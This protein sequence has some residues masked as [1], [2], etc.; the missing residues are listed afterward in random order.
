VYWGSPLGHP[1]VAEGMDVSVFSFKSVLKPGLYTYA[2]FGLGA[3]ELAP[4]GRT[5][6]QELL[7]TCRPE[8]IFWPLEKHLFGAANLALD[9]NG[10]PLSALERC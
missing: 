5:L 9:S 2:T 10:R 4:N 3:H 1:N 7:L 6:R 8:Y